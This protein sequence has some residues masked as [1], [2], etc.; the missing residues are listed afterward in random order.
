MFK[1]L[2]LLLVCLIASSVAF[3]PIGRVARQPT[4][5]NLFGINWG[6]KKVAPGDKKAVASKTA[7]KKSSGKKDSNE[8]DMTWGGKPDPAPESYVDEGRGFWGLKQK[9]TKA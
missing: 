5:Q 7:P 6:G 1:F 8:K 3:A 9:G 4:A 2:V